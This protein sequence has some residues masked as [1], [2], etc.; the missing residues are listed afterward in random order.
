MRQLVPFALVLCLGC[1]GNDPKP[2]D[3][4]STDAQFLALIDGS[5]AGSATDDDEPQ[6]VRLSDYSA[7]KLPGTKLIML[8]AAAGWCGPCQSEAAALSK[9][10]DD[11]ADR[12]VV[13]LSAIIEDAQSRPASVEF[14]RL[15]AREFELTVPLLIDSEFQTASFIDLNAMPCSVV[16]DAATMSIVETGIGADTGPDPLGKY[17]AL[18]DHA[19]SS[20]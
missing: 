9:F 19:L 8:V 10:A 5:D 20:L 4:V 15:W 7:E 1:A 14:A 6:L 13:V 2:A 17:R 3:D 18:L 12:G 11:Y 16:I